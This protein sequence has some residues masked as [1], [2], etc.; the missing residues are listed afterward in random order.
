M[1][2]IGTMKIGGIKMTTSKIIVIV[3]NSL[4]LAYNLFVMLPMLI[5][6]EIDFKKRQKRLNELFKEYDDTLYRLQNLIEIRS[7]LIDE[8]AKNQNEG[9]KYE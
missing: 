6:N 3:V 1:T 8:I 9:E 5:K 7:K 4:L 2:K